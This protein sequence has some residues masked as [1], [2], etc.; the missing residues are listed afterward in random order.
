MT[1]DP[2][3]LDNLQDIILPQPPSLWPPAPGVWVGLVV[4]LAVLAALILAVRRARQRSAYRRAG[5]ALLEVAQTARD[6][7]VILKRVALAVFPRPQVAPLYDD[8]WVAFLNGSCSST[9]FTQFGKTRPDADVTPELR[10][11]AGTWIRHHRAP[12][13][14][15]HST[16]H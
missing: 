14:R 5:L 6:V 10:S 3:S 15:A 9:S 8:D 4:G 12:A 13:A 2:H 11:C 1:T 16:E 7:N